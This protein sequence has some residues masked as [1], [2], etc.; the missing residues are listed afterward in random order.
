MYICITHTYIGCIITN[1]LTW[2]WHYHCNCDYPNLKHLQFLYAKPA[3][4]YK[5]YTELSYVELVLFC[6]CITSS[7][8]VQRNIL[9]CIWCARKYIDN[10]YTLGL[11]DNGETYISIMHS[12]MILITIIILMNNDIQ[13][14]AIFWIFSIL[15]LLCILTH[16]SV[17]YSTQ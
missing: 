10:V 13:N 4:D 5:I 1:R 3:V 11:W 14:I 17:L 7:V 15:K 6:R 12:K 2:Q 16:M 8:K 9:T